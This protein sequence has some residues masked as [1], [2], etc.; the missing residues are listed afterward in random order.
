MSVN[1]KMKIF[2]DRDS[3]AARIRWLVYGHQLPMRE[4]LAC[5]VHDRESL[6][7]VTNES[8]PSAAHAKDFRAHARR[9]Q[10]CANCG[11]ASSPIWP[12]HRD[13]ATICALAGGRTSGRVFGR[14]R[15]RREGDGPYSALRSRKRSTLNRSSAKRLNTSRQR[16]H[17]LHPTARGSL[18]RHQASEQS[19]HR[20]SAFIY[21]SG[22]SS[23]RNNSNDN[24]LP[25]FLSQ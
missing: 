23:G 12:E 11:Q 7:R 1:Q 4:H 13:F 5:P 24:P 16:R 25:L 20:E 3:P 10:L 14:L 15:R 6:L 19:E 9:Q 2:I 21:E 17:L 18:E 8:P 22:D